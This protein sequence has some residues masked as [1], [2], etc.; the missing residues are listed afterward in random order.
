VRGNRFFLFN[1]PGFLSGIACPCGQRI[2]ISEQDCQSFFHFR[3]VEVLQ[4]TGDCS[5]TLSQD[6]PRISVRNLSHNRC[7]LI[8]PSAL[9]T[10][11]SVS[12]R[13]LAGF[14]NKSNPCFPGFLTYRLRPVGTLPN[15]GLR[16]MSRQ[17]RLC[18]ALYKWLLN[19]LRSFT[20]HKNLRKLSWA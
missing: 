3:Y 6:M 13:A 14:I 10:P 15:H 9:S 12:C 18:F 5:C 2:R 20:V 7:C 16:K 1:I 19:I 11:I 17:I 8:T 4:L